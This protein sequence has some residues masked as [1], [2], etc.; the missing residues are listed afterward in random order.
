M[1]A[2]VA[3][4]DMPGVGSGVGCADEADGGSLEADFSEFL[5]AQRC[6][7]R[8]AADLNRLMR[9]WADR[10]PARGIVVVEPEPAL[11]R[12]IA[13]EIAA[14]IPGVEVTGSNCCRARRSA[15]SLK[16]RC[17]VARPEVAVRLSCFD[18]SAAD[19]VVLRTTSARE[20]R[21]AVRALQAGQVVTLLTGSRLLRRH[22]RELFAGDLGGSVGLACPRP[23]NPSE[24]DRA[25]RISSLV[26]TDAITF[27]PPRS[28]SPGFSVRAVHVVD[29]GWI[30]ALARYLGAEPEAAPRPL[31]RAAFGGT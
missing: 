17:L 21:C 25:L 9:R 24:L 27:V 16:G 31:A 5:L 14:G 2:S 4:G 12:L 20:H 23:S 1:G 11:R 7:G 15:G 29:P 26:L 8:L 3:P 18:P 30:R 19:T 22:A 6:K 28:P 10:S 13:A